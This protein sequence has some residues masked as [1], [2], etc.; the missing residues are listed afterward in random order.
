MM[1]IRAAILQING[2][3]VALIFK[4][5]FNAGICFSLSLLQLNKEKFVL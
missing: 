4:K 3:F 2:R 5:M 1:E